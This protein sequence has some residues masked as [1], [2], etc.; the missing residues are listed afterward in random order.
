MKLMTSARTLVVGGVVLMLLAQWSDVTVD[1]GLGVRVAN[2]HLMSRQQNLLIFGGFLLLTGVILFAM[3]RTRTAPSTDRYESGRPISYDGE[4]L[5][6]SSNY[7]LFLTRRF[8]IEKNATLGKFTIADDVFETLDASLV[9]ADRRY[10]RELMEREEQLRRVNHEREQEKFRSDELEAKRA[11]EKN[12]RDEENAKL[13]P[14]RRLTRRRQLRV[15]FYMTVVAGSAWFIWSTIN[16][17]REEKR[18]LEEQKQDAQ[19]MAAAKIRYDRYV[20]LRNSEIEEM[21]ASGKF[22]GYMIGTNNISELSR[23]LNRKPVRDSSDKYRIT[24]EGKSCDSLIKGGVSMPNISSITYV[25][26]S[27]AKANSNVEVEIKQSLLTGVS[28]FFDS[29]SMNH[30]MESMILESGATARWDPGGASKE[31]IVDDLG[32]G[33]YWKANSSASHICGRR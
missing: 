14:I 33:L 29:T 17:S 25:Y 27:V 6:S 28:I 11:I 5:I 9:E 8:S 16:S 4:R 13:A 15:A 21:Y 18:K 30:E 23:K 12:L 24:C 22:F 7:Q 26:C 20:S 3:A 31:I 32:V 2:L 1:T 19:D 10:G